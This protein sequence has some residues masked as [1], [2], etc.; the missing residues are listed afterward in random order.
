MIFHKI[1][2]ALETVVAI[3]L[4]VLFLLTCITVILRYFF[5]TSIYGSSE[6]SNYMFVYL[7]ALAAPL[8]FHTDS[9]INVDLFE[10]AS[11]K[12]KRVISSVQIVCMI[13]L[14]VLIFW[15]SLKWIQKVG[16][17]LTP[18]LGI[19]Q[20]YVQMAVPLCMGLGV[21]F[22]IGRLIELWTADSEAEQGGE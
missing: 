2:I 14:Q 21:F 1:W 16:D 22:C 20:K 5:N 12:K 8:L 7:T 19:P 6:I 18:L 11:I 3:W 9:H 4:M 15:Q 17:F 13:L 10:N